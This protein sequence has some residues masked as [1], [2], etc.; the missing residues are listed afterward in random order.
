MVRYTIRTVDGNRYEF[1]RADDERSPVDDP[2]ADWIRVSDWPVVR[3]FYK[4]NIVSV[5]EEYIEENE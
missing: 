4:K 1:E 2:D 3:M 5:Q